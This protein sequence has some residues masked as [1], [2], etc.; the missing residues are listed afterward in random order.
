MLIA[1]LLAQAV[2]AAAPEPPKSVAPLTVEPPRRPL[3]DPLV[4][5][6]QALVR[7][8]CAGCHSVM[9]TGVSLYAHAPP[10]RWMSELSPDALRK[11]AAEIAAGDHYAMPSVSLT[12]SESEAISAFIRAYAK[13]DPATQKAMSVSPCRTRYC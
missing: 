1:I 12:T 13:A 9:P 10:F 7:Q 8:R 4:A 3:S 5:R 6:G 11:V 2:A